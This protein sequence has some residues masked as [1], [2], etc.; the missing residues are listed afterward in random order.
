MHNCP[1]CLSQNT[2]TRAQFSDW[3]HYL[4][5]DRRLSAD[6]ER[7]TILRTMQSLDWREDLQFQQCR[8]CSLLFVA[9]KPD[10]D[11]LSEFYH[12][13][14]S[15]FVSKGYLRK[16][17]KKIKRAARRI[18]KLSGLARGKTFLDVGCNQGFAVEAAHRLGLQGTGIDIDSGALETARQHFPAGEFLN[19]DISSLAKSS[20]KFHIVYCTEVIEHVPDVRG[21]AEA[22]SLVLE[23]SGVL[24]LTTP[25]FGHFRRPRNFLEWNEVKPIEHIRWFSKSNIRRLFNSYGVESSFKLNTKPGIKMFGRKALIK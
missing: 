22:L 20:R 25:D 4:D 5:S 8:D 16:K 7:F 11:R 17:D 13:Y 9:P 24:F 23:N 18:K 2:D 19:M 14:Y 15:Q 6:D 21:F 10:G 12:T 1:A 3:V